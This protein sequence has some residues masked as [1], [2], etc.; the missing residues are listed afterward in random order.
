MLKSSATFSIIRTLPS[1]PGLCKLYLHSSAADLRVTNRET[2][3]SATRYNHG[4]RNRLFTSD[5]R[6]SFSRK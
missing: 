4:F 1:Y 2:A 6:L 5:G 3:L